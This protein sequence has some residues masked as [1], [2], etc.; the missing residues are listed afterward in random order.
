MA[1]QQSQQG[2]QHP[3][4]LYMVVWGL[5][6]VLSAFSYMVDY[7]GIQSYPRWSL[8]ILFMI[9]KAGLIMAIFMHMAWERLV[10]VYAILLPPVLVLVFAALMASESSYTALTRVTF[11]GAGS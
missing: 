4:R 1:Q 2:Q 9:L 8:I 6:F 5:L 3:I 10:L 7:L 11:M